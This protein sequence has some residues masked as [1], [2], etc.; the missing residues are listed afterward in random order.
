MMDLPLKLS[1]NFLNNCGSSQTISALLLTYLTNNPLLIQKTMNIFFLSR[2]DRKETYPHGS[3]A[4]ATSHNE[5]PTNFSVEWNISK[6][7][8]QKLKE[9][10]LDSKAT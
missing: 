5:L 2:S 10:P 1:I 9:S 7:V 6:H 3:Q 8:P 4:I